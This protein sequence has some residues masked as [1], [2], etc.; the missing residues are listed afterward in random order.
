MLAYRAF[1]V[2]HV[3]CPNSPP[4]RT[5]PCNV[6]ILP[7]L[8]AH[9]R[10]LL[11]GFVRRGCA[12]E[13]LAGL[14]KSGKGK[15]RVRLR[16]LLL[17]RRDFQYF[18]K[19]LDSA[20][21]SPLRAASRRIRKFLFHAAKRLH[22]GARP[23]RNRRRCRAPWVRRGSLWLHETSALGFIPSRHMPFHISSSCHCCPRHNTTKQFSYSGLRIAAH[24]ASARGAQDSLLRFGL[25][26]RLG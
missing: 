2:R 8:V 5:M 15:L 20:C 4:I 16:M 7:S 19:P 24:G 10:P 12:F 22:G 21:A 11:P 26:R 18:W 14:R 3:L 23:A 1:Q 25:L 13:F 17:L 6:A 9:D